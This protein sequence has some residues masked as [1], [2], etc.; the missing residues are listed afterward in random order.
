MKIGR[1]EGNEIIYTIDVNG[2]SVNLMED[3]DFTMDILG[4]NMVVSGMVVTEALTPDMTVLISAGIA[5]DFTVGTFLIG[6]ALVGVI[7]ASD[8]VNDRRDIIEVRRLIDNISPATRQFKD[9]DTED[10]TESTI[11]T[12]VQYITEIKVLA[13]VAGTGLSLAVETGWIK[14][15][16]ILVPAASLTVVDANIY[17]ID[18]EK[19]GVNNTNWT[20]TMASIHRNGTVSEMKSD[21]VENNTHRA[22]FSDPH[23]NLR[24]GDVT[25]DITMVSRKKYLVSGDY[26]LTLPASPSKGDVIDILS[27]GFCKIIQDDAEH[28]MSLRNKY[29]TTKGVNGYTRMFPGER[30]QLVYKGSGFSPIDPFVKV[31]ALSAVEGTG[32]NCSFSPDSMYLAV[33]HDTSPNITVYKRSGDTF[34]KLSALSSTGTG[35]GCSFSHDG[36]YLAVTSSISPYAIIYKRSGDVF[37]PLGGIPALPAGARDCMFSYDDRF[38]AYSHTGAPLISVYE[39][40][41]D[42]FALVPALTTGGGSFG[43]GCEFSFDG[44]LLAIAK[45]SSPYMHLYKRSGDIFTLMVGTPTLSGYSLGF[46]FSHDGVYLVAGYNNT[47]I[48]KRSGD[49]FIEVSIGTIVS[50][51]A[52]TF[53]FSYDDTYFALDKSGSPYIEVYKKIGDSF[54]ALS[55]LSAPEGSVND[56]RFSPDGRYLAVAHSTPPY[57]TVYR[58][59]EEIDKEWVVADFITI[60]SE[61]QNDG[62]NGDLQYRFK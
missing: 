8:P 39:R 12:E 26:E 15:A 47:K 14:I 17:N 19:A 43:N 21:I 34:T 49:S 44:N 22:N 62:A 20:T 52:H 59:K 2:N 40:S 5:K 56:C 16:E 23:I 53:D 10:I 37:T 31:S 25:S 13:G 30:L 4:A 61:N 51:S 35:R 24:R 36:T 9:P 45:Q 32:N 57:I 18:A 1:W 46:A 41:G 54:E 60:N 38:V 42:T 55:A 7:T 29:F 3:F 27:D 48:F 58:M 6:N 50:P 28:L 11:D 33:A